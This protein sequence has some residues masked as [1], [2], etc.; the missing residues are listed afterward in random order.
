ML[1]DV[2]LL[3][4]KTGRFWNVVIDRAIFFSTDHRQSRQV[5]Q[6]GHPESGP[7]IE[8]DSPSFWSVRQNRSCASKQLYSQKL[9][10]ALCEAL[11]D[12]QQ[13]HPWK[14]LNRKKK[15][16]LQKRQRVEKLLPFYVI[17]SRIHALRKILIKR[18][19][20][21]SGEVAINEPLWGIARVAVCWGFPLNLNCSHS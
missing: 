7:T 8:H 13:K 21:T 6:L 11:Q 10:G 5:T 16:N 9:A 20:W 1:T 15:K 18:R 17:R 3:T 12:D 2:S 4:K 14:T 19:V